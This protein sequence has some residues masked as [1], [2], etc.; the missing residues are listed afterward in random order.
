MRF[1]L[2]GTVTVSTGPD[3]GPG[4]YDERLP[5]SPKLRAL[6]AALLTAPGRPVPAD[7]LKAALWGDEPPATATA[8]L[9]NHVARLRRALAEEGRPSRLRAAASGYLLHV[10]DGELDAEVF[11]AHHAAARGAHGAQDWPAVL[12]ACGPA[13]ALWR[14]EPLSGVPLLSDALRAHAAHLAEA[15]LLTLEWRFDAELA[16][17][18][19]ETLT[20]ELASLTAA[21]PLRE[22]F[23]RQLMLALYGAGRQAEALTAFHRLRRTLIDEL[24][25]DPA[26]AVHGVYHHILTAPPAPAPAAPEPSAAGP[27]AGAAPP[28][29]GRVNSRTAAGPAQLP[30][31]PGD[32]AAATATRPPAARAGTHTTTAPAQLPPAAGADAASP[33]RTAPTAPADGEAAE[34][35]PAPA[36]RAPAPVQLPADVA[37]FTGRGG[38]LEAVTHALL[39]ERR[40][41][42][43]GMGGVGKTA[44]AVRAAHAVRA[45]F[46]D[47]VLYA[48]LRGFGVGGARRPQDL[49]SRFLGDLGRDGELPDDADD[50]SALLRETLHGLRVL[51]VLDNAGDAAQVAPLLPGGGGSAVLVTSRRTLADLP[52]AVRL[53]LEP[54]TAGEQRELLAAV[55]GGQ[56]VARDPAAAAE[57]MAACGGLPLALR[58]A[59]AR[60]ATRPNWPLAA[61]A[62]RLGGAAA[63]SGGRL[64]ALAAG[65]LAVEETFAMSYVAMRDGE[66][67]AEREAARAF[68]TLGVWP[69]NLLDAHTAAALLDRT[70]ASAEDAL[71]ALVD[72]H[73][74]QSPQPGRYAF[75]DLL[76]EYAA[77]RAAGEVPDPERVRALRRLLVWYAATVAATLPVLTPEGHPMPP[78]AE[79]PAVPPRE[80]GTTEDA[81]A[82]CVREMPALKEAIRQAAAHR[83]PEIAWRL[84]AGLFGYAQA[85]WWTGEWQA[86][87]EEAMACVEEC[88]DV[89]GR[90]WM[91]SRLG[92]AHGMA[93]RPEQC[94]GHLRAAQRY[95]ESA[96]DLRG[97]AAILTNMT[98]VLRM[99][100][101]YE[102]ALECGR[103]A[104]DLH[105]AAGDADR[106]ATLLGNLGD[107]HLKAGDAA[108]AERRYREAL[109]MWRDQGTL[110]MIAR[111]LTGLGDALRGLRRYGEA[112]AALREAIGVLDRIGDGATK[113]DVLETLGRAHAESGDLAA[114]RRC[115]W[116]GLELARTHRLHDDEAALMRDLAESDAG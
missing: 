100:G 1:G 111:M 50:R 99:T 116:E 68:R 115:W 95:F 112:L 93:H 10:E 38:E 27:A 53:A 17:G 31:S 69:A 61:L 20:P 39:T 89:L 114:A 72:A 85:Y 97:Q 44:L 41:V 67:P 59:G 77:G 5:G 65:G 91:H 28:P 15:R 30:P 54:L 109:G 107:T 92:V 82:W 86:C 66:Q 9:H 64:R 49:L 78:L 70:P 2:L 62:E 58:I 55:C 81:L 24:G 63:G 43:S 32:S 46:P 80:F 75:H 8:S 48:D 90:A 51:L 13:L 57:V 6:L 101:A 110:I 71:E 35:S 87:L 42:V 103:T 19:H 34:P 88:G 40:V 33:D 73:L 25:V 29:D 76:G 79:Q 102:Q 52:G 3:P 56:R 74:L 14:G 104:L 108:Q 45:Q 16:L 23:H 60:L 83:W 94:L 98:G 113:A 12:A 26:P 37:D 4:S 18:A 105:L 11:A 47:G 96:G 7:A 84:A 106:V 36:R 21:H 22:P